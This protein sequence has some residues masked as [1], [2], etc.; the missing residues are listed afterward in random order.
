MSD[1]QVKILEFQLL[2]S[3]LI[4]QTSFLTKNFKLYNNYREI[5]LECN[6]SKKCKVK[7]NAK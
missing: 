1:Y 2:V 7:S 3:K 4:Y 5:G 6:D